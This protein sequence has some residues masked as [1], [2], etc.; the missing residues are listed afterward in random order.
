MHKQSTIYR[1]SRFILYLHCQKRLILHF[2]I[3]QFWI[4]DSKY[5]PSVCIN[6]FESHIELI[7]SHIYEENTTIR[8]HK[9]SIFNA[10]HVLYSFVPPSGCI[11]AVFWMSPRAILVTNKPGMPQCN[12]TLT[13]AV[14]K[15][16][17]LQGSKRFHIAGK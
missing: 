4:S 13:K 1:K 11:S 5:D 10:I 17:A 14:Y 9:V 15:K 7:K 12:T 3:C 8:S 6:W 16:Q 2:Q